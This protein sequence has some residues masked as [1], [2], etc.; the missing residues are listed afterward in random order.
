MRNKQFNCRDA[1]IDARIESAAKFLSGT[2]VTEG[3]AKTKDTS[4]D[5]NE[6]SICPRSQILECH[7]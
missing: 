5:R 1:E 6:E 7:L 3:I 4:T 2:E